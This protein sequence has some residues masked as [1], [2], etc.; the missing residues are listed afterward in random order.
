[1]MFDN[2]FDTTTGKFRNDEPSRLLIVKVDEEAATAT[3]DWEV[4]LSTRS[5]DAARTDESRLELL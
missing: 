5:D 2:N 1:M 4:R 3:L